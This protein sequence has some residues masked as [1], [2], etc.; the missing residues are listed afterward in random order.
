MNK[1]E[2]QEYGRRVA[3]TNRMLK[4]SR[5]P[6]QTIREQHDNLPEEIKKQRNLYQFSED[7]KELIE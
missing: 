4:T 3:A 6:D 5:N 1:E 2:T 7:A